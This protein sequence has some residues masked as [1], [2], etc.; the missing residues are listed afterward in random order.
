MTLDAARPK[1]PDREVLE[2][3]S[4]VLAE[5]LGES[6]DGLRLRATETRIERGR[7]TVF[8]LTADGRPGVV[9]Y[10]KEMASSSETDSE[11]ARV[12]AQRTRDGLARA[13]ELERRLA[14]LIGDEPISFSRSL[15]VDPERLISVTLAVAGDPFGAT[16]RHLTTPGR[17]R[18][19]QQWMRITGKAARLIEE[20]TIV[21]LQDSDEDAGPRTGSRMKRLAEVIGP[22]Q[23]ASVGELLRTLREAVFNGPSPMVYAHGDLSSSNI[24][25]A[26]RLGL[27]DFGWVPRVRGYDISK[28]AF[29][30]EY[31]TALPR[32]A[33]ESLV[34]GLLEGFG[35]EGLAASPVWAY[36]RLWMASKVVADNRQRQRRR[37]ARARREIEEMLAGV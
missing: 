1:R 16:W 22:K 32:W 7:S 11:N 5:V 37:V 3:A 19:A 28:L 21:D 15:A 2:I 24:L 30:I 4:R 35:D 8:P 6:T 36:H 29:R 34:D 25:I 20:C 14:D 18:V 27:I 10:Y 12:R 13:V 17:S 33:V 23:A 31:G 26:E 9:A